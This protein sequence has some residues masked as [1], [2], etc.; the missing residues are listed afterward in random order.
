VVTQSSGGALNVLTSTN[1]IG[2]AFSM[3]RVA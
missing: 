3:V 1:V 2:P